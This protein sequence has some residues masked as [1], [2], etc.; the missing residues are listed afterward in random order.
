[1]SAR[2]LLGRRVI[3]AGQLAGQQAFTFKEP[4]PYTITIDNIEGLGEG[5]KMPIQVTPEFPAGI[6]ALVAVAALAASVIFVSRIRGGNGSN[7]FNRQ[8]SQ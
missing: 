3:A 5:V 7:L 1:M 4:G 2:L 6:L 8:G